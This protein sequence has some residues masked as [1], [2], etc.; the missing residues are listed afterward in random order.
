[1]TTTDSSET[2]VGAAQQADRALVHVAAEC[3]RG[4]SGSVWNDD[5]VI[6]TTARAVAGRESVEIVLDAAAATCALS[7]LGLLVVITR[8][9][10]G[11]H[12]G[13]SLPK[14]R[15][16][17]RRQKETGGLEGLPFR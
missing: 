5:G 2:W 10:L 12:N 3:R 7:G 17:S 6:L 16:D 14:V 15:Q 9:G 11:R 8:A 1:M 4:A 13:Q